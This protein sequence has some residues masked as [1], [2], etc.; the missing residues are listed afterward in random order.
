[1]RTHARTHTHIHTHTCTHIHTHKHQEI[2]I[3]YLATP[4]LLP[5]TPCLLPAKSKEGALSNNNH[6]SSSTSTLHPS[7]DRQESKEGSKG[8]A[9]AERDSEKY[10][11]GL[12]A[13]VIVE[14][15]PDMDN[16]GPKKRVL[17]MH[18]KYVCI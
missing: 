9:S 17:Y 18:I 14:E 13:S 11:D 4:C 6:V 2:A 10:F 15:G 3:P 1:V 12:P 8:G 16:K 7:Q 5:A